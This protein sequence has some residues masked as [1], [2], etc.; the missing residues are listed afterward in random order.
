M[1]PDYPE[2]RRYDQLQF[3]KDLAERSKALDD[4]ILAKDDSKARWILGVPPTGSA[5]TR[6]EAEVSE[7]SGT[8]PTAEA[9]FAEHSGKLTAALKYSR[10]LPDAVREEW[11]RK[12]GEIDLYEPTK[13]LVVLGDLFAR[14][15]LASDR[16]KPRPNIWS[17]DVGPMMNF[18]DEMR[19]IEWELKWLRDLLNHVE[20]NLRQ[21]PEAPKNE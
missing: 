11:M 10:T 17:V 4:A 21:H 8:P 13:G 16:C 18:A 12:V 2:D 9:Q 15:E 7:R 19:K 3:E 1:A 14:F 6:K 5:K 20:L